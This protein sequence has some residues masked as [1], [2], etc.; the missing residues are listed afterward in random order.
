MNKISW[1]LMVNN[2]ERIDLDLLIDYLKQDDPKLTHGPKVQQFEE[3]WSK[4]LGVSHSVMVNSGSSAND[5]TMLALRE[6]YGAGEI[7]VPALT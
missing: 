1:P 6:M 3:E 4:W 7:L 2:I 5:L